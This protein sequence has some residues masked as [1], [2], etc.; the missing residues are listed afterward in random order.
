[1]VGRDYL[2]NKAYMWL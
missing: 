1:M 2:R